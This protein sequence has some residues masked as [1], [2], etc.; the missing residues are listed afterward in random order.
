MSKT[1][2]EKRQ[3]FSTGQKAAAKMHFCQEITS[4][5]TGPGNKYILDITNGSGPLVR[6]K[7][8]PDY[9]EQQYKQKD[10]QYRVQ[11]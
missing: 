9:T 7:V 5:I 6:F 10:S 8:P 3:I 1:V 4:V 11:K 2:T